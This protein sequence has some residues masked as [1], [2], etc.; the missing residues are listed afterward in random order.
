[1]FENEILL[2]LQEIIDEIKKGTDAAECCAEQI[3]SQNKYFSL[4]KEGIEQ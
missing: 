3:E 2:K 4:N 1:M